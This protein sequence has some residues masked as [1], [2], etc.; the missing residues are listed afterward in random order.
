MCA[1]LRRT[2]VLHARSVHARYCTNVCRSVS[3]R[4]RRVS[5]RQRSMGFLFIYEQ[6]NP[7]VPGYPSSAASELERFQ[8]GSNSNA[9]GR[10]RCFIRRRFIAER[11]IS[12]EF[13][14]RCNYGTASTATRVRPF[15]LKH[16]FWERTCCVER[17]KEA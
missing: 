14:S 5:P 17:L 6:T 9:R 12:R 11:V 13:L 15:R 3:R 8:F 16:S 1:A 10:P 7:S 2:S 4:P